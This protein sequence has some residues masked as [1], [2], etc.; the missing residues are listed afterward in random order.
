[1]SDVTLGDIFQYGYCEISG[2]KRGKSRK[3]QI[4][5]ECYGQMASGDNSAYGTDSVHLVFVILDIS[6]ETARSTTKEEQADADTDKGERS[7]VQELSVQQL[8]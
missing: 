3:R 1:M 5:Q 4:F 7:I 2:S 6:D 8:E